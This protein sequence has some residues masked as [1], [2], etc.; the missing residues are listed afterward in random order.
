MTNA[1]SVEARQEAGKMFKDMVGRLTE[2]KRLTKYLRLFGAKKIAVSLT[3][4]WSDDKKS[5]HVVD[6]LKPAI[7]VPST[8]SPKK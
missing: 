7:A 5:N 2:F 8:P 6:I 4:T 3:I 1:S